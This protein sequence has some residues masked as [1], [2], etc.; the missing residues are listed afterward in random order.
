MSG[1]VGKPM[2]A[3]VGQYGC[4]ATSFDVDTNK[5][6]FVWQIDNTRV[7]PGSSYTTGSVVGN[8]VFASTYSSP[9]YTSTRS[10]G[11]V[12]YAEKT[13][14]DIEGPAAWTIVGYEKPRPRCE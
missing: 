1:F 5:R 11:Y 14:T 2:T 10:C 13:R 4:P 9:G 7:V 3:V 8:Q 6:A 12:L